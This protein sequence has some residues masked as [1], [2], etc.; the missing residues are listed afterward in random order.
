MLHAFGGE[1]TQW[2]TRLV[3]WACLTSITLI[4]SFS[5][6][7]GLRIQTTLALV[8]L[9]TLLFL[10]LCG[11]SVLFGIITI[12]NRP[13]N[14]S[15]VWDGTRKDAN[16]FVSGLYSVIVLFFSPMFDT[17]F[18]AN[19]LLTGALKV[20]TALIMHYQRQ[21]T[22]WRPCYEQLLLPWLSSLSCTFLSTFRIFLWYRNTIS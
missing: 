22:P 7:W 4:H 12:Q 9:G 19:L 20:I 10:I 14:F 16:A 5:L 11:F 1:I 6:N 15:N 8:K 2:N 18:C 21:K 3:G 13:N 17:P